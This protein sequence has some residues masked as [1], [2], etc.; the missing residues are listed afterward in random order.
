MALQA[1]V[2]S[3][4]AGCDEAETQLRLTHDASHSLLEKAG[5]L[6]EERFVPFMPVNLPIPQ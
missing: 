4:R 6:R 5:N 2:T 3:L 1:H